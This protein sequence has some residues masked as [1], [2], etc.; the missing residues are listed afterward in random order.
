MSY[1]WIWDDARETRRDEDND[2]QSERVRA[3]MSKK[4][5]QE[6]SVW[7]IDVTDT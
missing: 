7:E 2:K 1:G 5:C 4:W 6:A 3:K